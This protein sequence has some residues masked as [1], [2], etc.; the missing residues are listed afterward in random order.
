MK[1]TTTILSVLCLAGLISLADAAPLTPRGKT[2][3]NAP[4]QFVKSRIAAALAEGENTEPEG[5][6]K[7][8]LWEDF[9][10]LPAGTLAEPTLIP[11]DE[12]GWVLEEY[13]QVPDWSAVAA[14]SV[15]GACL[16]SYDSRGE[17]GLL[18]TPNLSFPQGGTLTMRVKLLGEEGSGDTFMVEYNDADIVSNISASTT[19]LTVGD[20]VDISVPVV[21]Y[22]YETYFCF[23]TYSHEIL[24]DDIEVKALMPYIMPPAHLS[25]NNYTGTSFT[26]TWSA[27]EE[28][29]SY[30]LTVYELDVKGNPI[31]LF[32][33]KEVIET[34]YTVTD[35]EKGKPYY[36]FVKAKNAE[37]TSEPSAVAEVE[38]LVTPVFDEPVVGE[39][40]FTVSW[41]DV[42][43]ATNYDFWAYQICRTTMAEF[44]HPINLMEQDFSSISSTGTIDAPENR[45]DLYNY[46]DC[47]P[48]W[49][50]WG[51]SYIDGAIGLNTPA[52]D[53]GMIVYLESPKYD[54]SKV[55]GS[56]T[57]EFDLAT[58]NPGD[59][60]AA[61][62]VNQ[63][64]DE[65]LFDDGYM[66]ENL[67][68][69]WS[70]HTVSLKGT[71][72]KTFFL[73]SPL[74]TGRVFID[75]L[76]I[77]AE[78]Q[79]GGTE[80]LVPILQAVGDINSVEVPM[81]DN[82]DR[83]NYETDEYAYTV[84]CM[85]PP[86]DGMGLIY[87]SFA[88]MKY[89]KRETAIESVDADGAQAVLVDGVLRIENPQLAPI[90]VYNAGGALVAKATGESVSIALAHRGVY[91]VKVGDT[92]AKVI[93]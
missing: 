86:A 6:L 55:H 23:Y 41:S 74:G 11:T 57:I 18:W 75:N 51:P 79:D 24:I 3:G 85:G 80:V 61:Y 49:I 92:V 19:E 90:S 21:K 66:V 28:A 7:T 53:N 65:M 81:D 5:V 20:W 67:T 62:L 29:T 44:F 26:A 2:L 76:K 4:S 14:Y 60:L 73:F 84:R 47:L 82:V 45:D 42:E 70:H 68:K 8:T 9:S 38:A 83:S 15:D 93:Y 40:S 91:L 77:S 1:K 52:L 33:D 88:D 72:D 31:Y 71:T 48:G 46:V 39:N 54:L 36:Y 64:V 22:G 37:H 12:Y 32:E 34:S 87:S 10:K 89:V 35:I 63:A 30:L 59:G 58:D 69:E 50:L 43:G 17:T 27:V 25:F 56:V 13:T 16:L 78:F